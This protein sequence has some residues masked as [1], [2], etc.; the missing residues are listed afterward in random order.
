MAAILTVAVLALLG[1]IK[2]ARAAPSPA[3]EIG[4]PVL[5]S[6]ASVAHCESYNIPVTI[7]SENI[8]YNISEFKDNFDVFDPIGGVENVT[9][10]YTISG[11]FC[12]PKT[13]SGREKT[14]L[15]ATHG[16]H[17]DGRYW[18]SSY[19]PEEYSFVEA[20]AAQ[21]YSVFYYD[22]LGTGHSEK[23][24]GYT[25]QLST[26]TEIIA[27]LANQLRTSPSITNA[28]GLPT[29]VILVGHSFGSF[30]SNGVAT[31]HPTA[32]D[33]IILTGFAYSSVP[34]GA[35][36][37]IEAFAPRI[38][39]QLNPA[40]YAA[41]DTGYLTFA[42]MYAHINTFFKKPHY[43]IETARFAS[44]IVQPFAIAE[45]LSLTNG[46]VN[47]VAPAF[48]GP[49]YIVAGEFDYA[50]CTG[51]CYSSFAEAG[52]ILKGIF[53]KSR[54]VESYVHPGAAHGINF[55]A[56]ATGFY[57]SI[58]DFLKKAGY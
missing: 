31:R 13:F 20:M 23:V 58:G 36:V 54:L 4:F 44:S 32:I 12:Y 21:G 51:E 39:A 55:A 10:S 33:A 22:R 6:N 11:T 25:N 16:L 34:W 37:L 27:S 15:L 48:T 41:L 40:C 38:A 50:F 53:P 29:S 5:R 30:A 3:H 42:D 14:V 46:R 45:W 1:R 49:V 18:D 19:K 26:Q 35:N 43:D 28:T 9:A 52:P 2:T 47:P 8:I 57:Q 17:Y 56:N 7:T 24:S